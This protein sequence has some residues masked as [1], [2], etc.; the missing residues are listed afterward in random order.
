MQGKI[1]YVNTVYSLFL[2]FL[3]SSDIEKNVYLFNEDFS[4]KILKNIKNKII[5]RKYKKLPKIIRWIAI[6]NFL[7]N[8]LVKYKKEFEGGKFHIQDHLIYSQFLLNNINANF[9]L[10]EDGT[11][12]YTFIE[13]KKEEKMKENSILYRKTYLVEKFFSI[14]GISSKIEKIYLTGILPIPKSI[15]QKVELVK[16]SELWDKLSN[17]KKKRILTIFNIELSMIENLKNLKKGILLITQPLSEDR[18][19]SEEEKIEIY[20][21]ILLNKKVNKVF[22]KIHPRERTDYKKYFKEFDIEIIP[23]EFPIEILSFF[24]IEFEEVVTL[25]STSVF[26]FKHRYKID[27]IGVNNYSKLLEKFGKINF[28]SE[29]KDL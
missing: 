3:I 4:S 6:R 9:F 2:S 19:I 16:I 27:F 7:K 23:K 1:I 5:L 22:L 8:F 18:I 20:R 14:M 10:V 28:Q 13:D 15:E 11:I 26:N 12:N 21:E 29:E 17:E 25:F 24:N